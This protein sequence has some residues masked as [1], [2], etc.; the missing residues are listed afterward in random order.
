MDLKS[1]TIGQCLKERAA[2]TPGAIGLSWGNIRYTWRELDEISDKLALTFLNMGMERGE[3]A[4]LWGVNSPG[5]IFHYYALVKIGVI[6]VLI[7]ICFKDMELR[8][9]L[10][11]GDISYLFYDEKHRN[12]RLTD[13]V[14][15]IK[16][17]ELPGLK[18]R[19]P[20]EQDCFPKGQENDGT[21]FKMGDENSL[22]LNA[23]LGQAVEVD[24]ANILFTSGTSCKP[25]G[26]MLTHKN[27]VNNSRELVR[28]MRWSLEDRFCLSVPLFHCFG[29]TAG[30]L[31]A[32]HAGAEVHLLSDYKSRDVMEQ[33]QTYRCTVL[34]GVP[35][36]F[37][38][39]VRNEFR[40]QYD[41]SSLNSGI[42]AGSPIL[43]G[44]YLE[45]CRS[46]KL[47]HLQVSYGQTESSPCI[48][49][50]D[51][52]EA[53]EEK[54]VSSG[55]KIRDIQLEIRDKRTN[56]P[57]NCGEIGEIVTKGYH[58]M[59]GYYKN[60][61]DT[62]EVIDGQGWLHTGDLGYLDLEGRLHITGRQ[63]EVIIRGGENISP[64]EIEDCILQMKQ[65]EQVK[66]IGVPAS[67]LQEEIAACVVLSPGTA[68]EGD[69]I[70]A[71]VKARLSDYKVPKYVLTFT[72][73]PLGESG[74]VAVRV[75]R[76][77]VRDRL[78]S[79]DE[80]GKTCILQSSMN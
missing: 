29:I 70:K 25:K 52:E 50:T 73:L 2:L 13:I 43:P 75:L 5:W 21:V 59:K 49:I 72:R 11:D 3:H 22:L 18:R 9:V 77:M 78:I 19:I 31:A 61:E 79:N 1:K 54:A 35:T 7:N 23:V 12:G 14:A 65:V 39:L 40:A 26:V 17:E 47:E 62:V 33:V 42:I 45:I 34:N 80:G 68:V 24:T 56:K 57:L 10:L 64:L 16:T 74:K 53:I 20:M 69:E 44:E 41:L 66:V 8:K 38:A 36:M 32:L 63:K 71:F 51:Y 4:A 60:P 27:L 76:D 48:T 55:R 28:Q 58:V 15:G 37:L 6:P 46:L 30:I 67:V